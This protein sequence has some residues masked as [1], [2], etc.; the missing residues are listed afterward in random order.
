MSDQLAS[1]QA[2]MGQQ[3]AA[4]QAALLEKEGL[5]AE[6]AL[7]RQRSSE[8]TVRLAAAESEVHRLEGFGPANI[9]TPTPCAGDGGSG[10]SRRHML[11]SRAVDSD[12]DG[13]LSPL[14]RGA[15]DLHADK[16]EALSTVLGWLKIH[17]AQMAYS[18]SADVDMEA[19][20]ITVY[21]RLD[22]K[23]RPEPKVKNL[24]TQAKLHCMQARRKTVSA[25]DFEQ[26]L[27]RL[28]I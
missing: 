11:L 21:E 7:E 12:N 18:L 23:K 14:V 19:I 25:A 17:S 24:V 16:Q 2:E 9:P 28:F 10:S 20:A 27:A 6:A 15:M 4:K 8:L 3:V 13:D 5:T 1:M 22:L 26:A